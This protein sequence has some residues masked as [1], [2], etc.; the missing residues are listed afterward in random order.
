MRPSSGRGGG[1]AESINDPTSEASC[2]DGSV[3]PGAVSRAIIAI[4]SGTA[5]A[6]SENESGPS[7][8]WPRQTTRLLQ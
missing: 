6:A 5:M 3:V 2:A 8:L 1:A 7:R 4:C